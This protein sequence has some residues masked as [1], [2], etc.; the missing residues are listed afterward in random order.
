MS[1]RRFYEYFR[2]SLQPTYAVSFLIVG[3]TST[4]FR[5]YLRCSFLW[6]LLRPVSCF[7]S[8]FVITCRWTLAGAGTGSKALHYILLAAR[9]LSINLW[10]RCNQSLQPSIVFR[11]KGRFSTGLVLLSV[12]SREVYFRSALALNSKSIF[13]CRRQVLRAFASHAV[14]SEGGAIV[15]LSLLGGTARG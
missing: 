8:G 5:T 4:C 12:L 11:W 9:H 6:C 14:I 10:K 3:G 13:Q 2:N 15:D 7:S 1:G